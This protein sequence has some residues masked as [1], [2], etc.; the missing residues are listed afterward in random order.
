ILTAFVKAGDESMA[1]KIIN[2]FAEMPLG[3]GKFNSINNLSSYLAAIKST[4]KVKKGVD[5]IVEFRE[6]VPEAFRGQT[7]PFINGMILKGLLTSKAE[8]LKKDANNAALGEL[9][10]YIKSKLPEED[11]KGF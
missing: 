5:A 10:N 3:Q 1:D 9:V 8:D 6:A 11:K 4:E 2:D 7:D